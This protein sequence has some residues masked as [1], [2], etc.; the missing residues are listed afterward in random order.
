[1][2][3]NTNDAKSFEDMA[4]E[5]EVVNATPATEPATDVAEEPVVTEAGDKPCDCTECDCKETPKAE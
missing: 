5:Q 2:G 4:E 1:M 3:F